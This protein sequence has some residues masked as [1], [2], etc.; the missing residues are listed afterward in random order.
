MVWFGAGVFA[1]CY[2]WLASPDLRRERGWPRTDYTGGSTITRSRLRVSSLASLVSVTVLVL[3]AIGVPPAMGGAP[4]VAAASCARFF[5]SDLNGVAAGLAFGPQNRI[6]VTEGGL[7]QPVLRGV[8]PAGGADVTFSL[9]DLNVTG[10]YDPQGIAAGSDG[11]LWIAGGQLGQT[12]AAVNPTTGAISALPLSGSP[13]RVA[14]GPDGNI[15]VTLKDADAIAKVSTAGVITTYPLTPG[16]APL[17]ITVASDGALWFTEPGRSAIG[18]MTTA[19]AR[20]EYTVGARPWYIATS[21]PDIWFTERGASKVGHLNILGAGLAEY[22]TP[23]PAAGPFGITVGADGGVWFTEHDVS[24]VGRLDPVLR[25]INETLITASGSPA[26]AM[27]AVPDGTIWFAVEVNHLEHF[28][29]NLNGTVGPLPPSVSLTAGSPMQTTLT[30]PVYS[31]STPFT[32]AATTSNQCL[33]S[34]SYRIYAAG[35]TPGLFGPAPASFTLG[36]GTW[37]VEF[38]GTGP[39][40]DSLA[41]A[42]TIFVD[43]AR[44]AGDTVAPVLT[45]PTDVSVPATEVGGA[46]VSYFATAIDA[47][48]GAVP[49]TCVPRSGSV[50]A[51]GVTTVRCTASDLTGNATTGSFIVTVFRGPPIVTVADLVVPASGPTPSVTFD[52]SA[53]S[54]WGGYVGVTCTPPGLLLPSPARFTA[55]FTANVVTAVTCTSAIDGR[56]Q[57]GTASFTVL[58]V[59]PPAVQVPA[60]ITRIVTGTSAVVTYAATASSVLDGPL[61]PVCGPPSG[62]TFPLGTTIVTCTATD[63]HRFST[64]QTFKVTIS[65]TQPSTLQITSLPILRQGAVTVSATLLGPGGAPIIGRTV[66]FSAGGLTANGITNGQGV[67]SGS[68]GLKKGLYALTA[69]FSG[70]A[71]FLAASTTTSLAVLAKGGDEGRGEREAAAKD[72]LHKGSDN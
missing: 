30:G 23:T 64:A 8:S 6:W 71:A 43:A 53:H 35:A 20:T 60:D 26:T 24:K 12:I 21:G 57:T 31:T 37:I 17:D 29:P 16:A 40:G 2:R 46:A 25:T 14:A 62:S 27:L 41:Q 59:T 39:G 5:E 33:D 52:A 9:G 56:G 68:L 7:S 38:Y 10:M 18:R 15:W 65:N 61:T 49:V 58:P 51:I 11:R 13:M 67:A 72:P 28:K 3:S 66:S 63:T 45:L 50:F 34:T 54:P 22:G 55:T 44:F 48:D 32:I 69:T 70:D 42:V 19:G 4:A 1:F 36:D 47:K